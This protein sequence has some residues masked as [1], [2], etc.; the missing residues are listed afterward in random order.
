VKT[1]TGKAEF[2][3]RDG[4]TATAVFNVRRLWMMNIYIG[5]ITLRDRTAGVVVR[6]P[7]LFSPVQSADDTVS[8]NASWFTGFFR[9]YRLSWSVTDA[10][11]SPTG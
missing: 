9:W 8:G 2:P 11:S 3:G 4:G 1:I 5:D 10:S 7:V 6:T